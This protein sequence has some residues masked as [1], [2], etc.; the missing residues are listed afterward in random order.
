MSMEEIICIEGIPTDEQLGE[1][2]KLEMN[3]FVETQHTLELLKNEF[4]NHSHSLSLIA[5]IEDEPVGFK[6]GYRR[7]ANEFYSWLGGVH[8]DQRGKGIAKR[9][10]EKQHELAKGHGYK[11]VRTHTENQF[12]EMLILNLKMGFDMI[13]TFQT[14]KGRLR[15]ILEKIL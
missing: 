10:M 9:L 15:L 4:E 14:H 11:R 13:G 5:Y 7:T 6:I 1:I 2:L 12:K 3:C 8:P